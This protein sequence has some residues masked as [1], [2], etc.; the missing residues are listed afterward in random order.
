[1]INEI[2]NVHAEYSNMC[3][4]KETFEQYFNTIKTACEACP[5]NVAKPRNGISEKR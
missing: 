2:G 3:S 5:A 1:M 4:S